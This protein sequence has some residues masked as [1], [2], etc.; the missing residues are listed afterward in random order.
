MTCSTVMPDASR[1]QMLD[2][3]K[4]LSRGEM[5]SL[6]KEPWIRGRP[7]VDPVKTAAIAAMVAESQRRQDQEFYS[8]LGDESDT[9]N[10]RAEGCS[11]GRISLG[12]YCKIHHFE[13]IKGRPCPFSD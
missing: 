13:R 8:I 2:F 6:Q 3:W 9:E 7:P 4:R 10:C 12:W 5:E 11:R 1:V